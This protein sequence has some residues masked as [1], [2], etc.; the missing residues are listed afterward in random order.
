MPGTSMNKFITLETL[1]DGL[2]PSFIVLQYQPINIINFQNASRYYEFFMHKIDLDETGIMIRSCRHGIVDKA[3]WAKKVESSFPEF[4][5]TVEEMKLFLGRMHAKVHDWYC[6][7]LKQIY[8][9]KKQLENDK[10]K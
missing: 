8:I 4:K 9:S 6:Q 3:D 2:K 10:E 5:P 7:A 1:L